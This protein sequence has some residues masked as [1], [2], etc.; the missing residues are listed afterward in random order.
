MKTALIHDHLAQDGGAERV[1]VALQDI[2]PESPTYTLVYD[3]KNSV[4]VKQDKIRTSF[5]QKIPWGVKKYQW[6]ITLMPTATES[7][8]LKEYDLILSSSAI[9]AKGVITKP[10]AVHICYCHTPPRFLWTDSHD[11]IKEL[12]QN[13]LIKSFLPF[14]LTSLRQ[15]DKIAAERV[16]YFI[17]NSREVQKR[18]R[19]YYKRESEI[20]YPPVQID[21]YK[22]AP[23]QDDYFLAGGRLVGYKR[24]DLVVEA[25][26]RLN[27]PLIIFGDGP[28]KKKL[29]AAA[30]PNIKFV[31]RVSEEKK[32]EL[33]SHC[34]AFINPQL[35]DFGITAVEAMAS[36]RPVLAYGAGGAL[37]TIVPGKTGNFFEEQIWE[38]IADQVLRFKSQDYNP[39][40]IRKHA[41]NFDVK[42]FKQK[43]QDFVEEKMNKKQ[44][45]MF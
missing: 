30:K 29:R 26:N 9:F 21:K 3:K 31:G 4:E 28:L 40:E 17:A 27:L 37:E 5:L 18:I 12:N 41:K 35:E 19:K 8:N 14:I 36:G 13:F 22:I 39:E 38:D 34:Q 24:F 16:D 45:I 43:I 23:R 15:W 2:Y 44:K 7:F 1:A 32:A 25:F 6:F 10:E 33:Y 11:Y 20:I 42:I